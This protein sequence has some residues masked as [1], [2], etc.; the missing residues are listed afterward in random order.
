MKNSNFSFFVFL[1]DN[2]SLKTL[3]N[4]PAGEYMN[5]LS[6]RTKKTHHR[7]TAVVNFIDNIY[8]KKGGRL[9]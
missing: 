9:F 7:H 4:S 8:E 5:I 1:R 2:L 3:Q 6:K